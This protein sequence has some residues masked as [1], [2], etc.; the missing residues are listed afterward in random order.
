MGGE[1][2]DRKISDTQLTK[3]EFAEKRTEIYRAYTKSMT[4]KDQNRIRA[5]NLRRL[6]E[7]QAHD[8]AVAE[9]AKAVAEKL[10]ETPP[11]EALPEPA[12]EPP[13]SPPPLH[14]TTAF[15]TPQYSHNEQNH[16]AADQD[17]P[18][19]GMPGRFVDD[20]EPASAIS[21]ATTEI[22]NEPQTEA[23]RLGRMPS[24]RRERSG[25][26]S[27][28]TYMED[29]LSA[30]QAL[31]G[32]QHLG[33]EEPM[34]EG[35]SI[36]IML[37]PATAVDPP[38]EPT[39]TKNK[40]SRDPSP[41]GAYEDDE[42]MDYN[43]PVFATTLTV[44]SPLDS[45]PGHSEAISP[46]SVDLP[47]MSYEDANISDASEPHEMK[48]LSQFAPEILLQQ[49]PEIELPEAVE[50]APRFQLPMLRTALAPPSL[51]PSDVS[52]DYLNTPGTDMEYESSDSAAPN[53]VSSEGRDD[54]DG[55]V[56]PL[57]KRR[58]VWSD[59]NRE[60][61]V[62]QKRTSA[63]TDF[64]VETGDEYSEREEPTQPSTS[65]FPTR[66]APR[67]PT[68]QTEPT[69][70]PQSKP[71]YSPLPSPRFPIS[72]PPRESSNRHQ[73]PPLST[74]GSF[75]QE[76]SD[77]SPAFANISMPLWPSYSPPP[78]PHQPSESSP[79]LSGRS[80]P[81][82]SLYNRRP[83][84]S[85]YQ[86]SQNGAKIPE[87]R[88]ASDD[89]YS[90]RASI[91]T[92]RSSTT[93][94]F[95]EP[96]ADL[97]FK[98]K[99]TTTTVASADEVQKQKASGGEAQKP[100]NSEEEAQMQKRLYQRRMVIKE[101]IDTESVYLKDMNVVEEIYKG[102]AEACPKL[103][104]GD[105]KVI[106]RNTDEIVAF[107]T[108]FLD[109]LKS[110][111][112]S[113]YSSRAPK[114]SRHSQATTSPITDD[115]SSI[116]PTLVE[117][118]DE[119]KDRKTSIGENFGKHLPR[120]QVVYADFLKSSEIASARLAVLQ[121]DSAVK[122]WLSECN[123]VAKDLTQAWDLD[124]LLVKPVQRVTRY[125][126]L[127]K[128]IMQNT[129]KDHPDFE[130]LTASFHNLEL[131]LKEIDDMKER[132]R[133]V[134]KIVGRKR[135]ESDVRSNLAK[136]FGRAREAKVQANVNRPRDDE[137]YV[138]LHEKYG[139]DYLRLQ[140]VLRDVEFYTRQVTIWTN[141]FLRYL[142]SME[143]SMRMSASPYPELESKWARFNMSMR[144]M[145]TIALEDHVK[146]PLIICISLLTYI[147][148]QCSK[149]GY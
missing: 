113:V 83:P 110:A 14:I 116:A 48:Q 77:S 38:A 86:S 137:V 33:E 94:P 15:H 40:F 71:E 41:P 146:C 118:T 78:P 36:K 85:L 17:S 80:P 109:A 142:S 117:E 135:K 126:L 133:T 108:M 87:S 127:L 143:L 101:L 138:K 9:A 125:K 13:A 30:E 66:P 31:F 23:A 81:P 37:E 74:S 123:L 67:A 44:A 7:R 25:L 103:E 16:F 29:G 131:L 119:V 49:E 148:P 62:Q 91:S 98:S 50:E 96:P 10:V 75:A 45:T 115:K 121:G 54:R 51:T 122:V 140:V 65:S 102:T 46:L 6:Q 20:D 95:E 61:S 97:S 57:Q 63:W 68:E 129:P 69:A 92:P 39:P 60:L 104:N 72:I 4:L 141:D 111:G 1:D 128:E 58:S 144:D 42:Y 132:L 59:Y 56:S 73:L 106:F 93:M 107:S 139:D 47:Q 5:A 28:V 84:S 105:I 21:N 64:S 114:Q 27:H 76:I 52:H 43:Q 112:A 120:M 147:G 18:T 88:R 149:K 26:S 8:L 70:E 99:S 3:E 35:D 82:P 24:V 136:A 2:K 11:E 145:G 79:A 19:L 100:K 55:E 22:D 12:A 124:A 34:E 89:V 134:G 90:P 32:S 53:I 130:Y